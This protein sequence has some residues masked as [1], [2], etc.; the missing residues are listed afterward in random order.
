MPSILS[1]FDTVQ[2]ALA[3]QQFALS[4]TQKNVANANNPNYTRQDVVN[5]GDETEWVRSGVPGVTLRATRDR[6]LDYSISQELQSL[7][8]YNVASDALGQIDSILNG[9]GEGLQQAISHFFN[10]FASLSSSPEDLTLRQ[11][12][13]SSAEALSREFQRLYGSIQQVQ[14]SQDQALNTAVE[15]INSITAQI[16]QW[17]V[18]VREAQGAHSEEEFT[19]R[20]SRQQL[21]EKLSSL[22]GLSYY[23]TE[24]GAITLTTRQGGL[25]VCEEQSWDLEIASASSGAFQ[26]VFLNGTEI[27]NS[28]E[29]GKLGGLID[30]RDSK[31][32]GY[33]SALDEIAAGIISRVNE[34][35]AQGVD[36][37]GGAGGDFFVPFT[38]L[39]PGSTTGAARTMA[40]SITDPRQVAAAGPGTGAGNNANARLLA[41]IADERLFNSATASASQ[42]YS[43]LIYQIGIDERTAE[44]NV[45]TQNSVLDQLKN[46]RDAFSGVNLDEEAVSI[47]KYQKAYQASARY[48][49]VLD[50]LSDEILNLL[51]A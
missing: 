27:T 3:A 9:S 33:L 43:T 7:A 37:D 30:L 12:V 2:Q 44:E 23:E 40:V 6:F 21:V 4:I 14:T 18:K 51:G 26:G 42:F 45:T 41:A 15:E 50:L 20:D 32:A 48:A 17:N 38:P 36:L 49:N 5:T 24:S 46:Q 25:L 10:G 16:A 29:S 47:I 19:L 1:G 28:I 8:E 34:Q 22:M 35:H 31:I 39:V 13:L 11:N